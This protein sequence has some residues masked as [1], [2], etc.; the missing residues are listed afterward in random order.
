M[1]KTK[2]A[3]E[4]RI[5][6]MALEELVRWPRNPKLHD[7]DTLGASIR[8]FGFVQPLTV[9][10]R[11][12]RLVAGHGRLEALQ[13][14]AED[15]SAPPE[16]V[17]TDSE[18]RWLVPVIR[19]VGFSSEQE[20][21]DYLL[22]DNRAVERGGWDDKLL[23]ALLQ[24]TQ[25]N[26]GGLASVGFSEKELKQLLDATSEIAPVTREKTP[27][28]LLESYL[29]NDVRRMMLFFQGSVYEKVVARIEDIMRANP[30]LKDHTDVFTFLLAYYESSAGSAKAG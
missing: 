29:E 13:K 4:I 21:Q 22:V 28:V 24:E 2:K 7:W 11:S 1:A 10:E 16:R 3:D 23:A 30:Q 9:D 20:A 27:E 8:R 18:G 5:E 25:Q 14:M 26:V 12:G 17:K 15:G 6:Y 19:G